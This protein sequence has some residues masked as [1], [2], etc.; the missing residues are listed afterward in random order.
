MKIKV[1]YSTKKMCVY[2]GILVVFNIKSTM[3]M[4]TIV[5][6]Y[7]NYKLFG[8]SIELEIVYLIRFNLK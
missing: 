8:F 5:T 1:C 4:T 2:F 3:S 7:Y 6:E